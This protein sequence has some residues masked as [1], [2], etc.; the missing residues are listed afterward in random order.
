MILELHAVDEFLWGI[1][2]ETSSISSVEH[3][4]PKHLL[5]CRNTLKSF[6]KKKDLPLKSVKF[7]YYNHC[8]SNV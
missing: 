1:V 8:L 3:K 6:E 5:P 7:V 4:S 2:I